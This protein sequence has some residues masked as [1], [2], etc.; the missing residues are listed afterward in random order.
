[1]I[2]F[3]QINRLDITGARTIERRTYFDGASLIEWVIGDNGV[4]FDGL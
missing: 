4:P 2:L 1:M 3:L